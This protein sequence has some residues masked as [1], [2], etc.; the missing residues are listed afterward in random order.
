MRKPT[1]AD[2]AEFH[3]LLTHIDGLIDGHT[4]D[5]ADMTITIDDRTES[6]VVYVLKLVSVEDM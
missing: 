6:G 3:Q 4:S 2:L 1:G 5:E